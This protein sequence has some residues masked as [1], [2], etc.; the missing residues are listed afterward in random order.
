MIIFENRL[1]IGLD[2]EH[3]E[4]TFHFAE[5]SDGLELVTFIGLLIKIPFFSIY[6]GEFLEV[7]Q[8]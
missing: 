2:I 7:E 8:E 3:S 1:G 5:T 4:D 6:I